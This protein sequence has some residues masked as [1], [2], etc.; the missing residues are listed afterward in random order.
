MLIKQVWTN[1][2][3]R[4]FFY[5]VTCPKTAETLA[6]DPIDAEMCLEIAK[7]HGWNIKHVLN[8]HEHG[9][10]IGGNDKVIKETGAKLLGPA[11][12]EGKISGIDE[13]LY[14]G[15]IVKIGTSGEFKVLETPGHTPIHI[16]LYGQTD[17]TPHFLCGDTLFNAGVGHCRSGD[18]NVLYNTFNNIISD[19][20]DETKIY[21]GHEY[22]D[23]NLAFTLDREPDNPLAAD[24]LKELKNQD[25]DNARITT[26]GLERQINTFLRLEQTTIQEGIKKEFPDLPNELDKK[27]VFLKLREL[28]NNW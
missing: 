20:P 6:I 27:T 12:A 1:N 19:L 10:H 22:M 8:T 11:K 2:G 16:S 13:E 17:N 23:N 4:N 14:D 25:L 24:L 18:P 28:R 3:G 9:D 5:M 21:P 7:N 15:S 26:L